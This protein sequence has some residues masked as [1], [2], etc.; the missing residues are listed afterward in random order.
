MTFVK[1][2]KRLQKRAG[3]IS[4]LT[5]GSGILSALTV[6]PAEASFDQTEINTQNYICIVDKFGEVKASNIPY[7]SVDSSGVFTLSHYTLV[8]GETLAVGDYILVGENCINL[9]QWDD[10][11]EGYLI[12]HA[13]YEAKYGDSSSWTKAAAEDMDRYFMKLAGSF[14]T[15]SDD[16]SEI[17]VTN[18][19]YI[20]F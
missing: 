9:P 5:L 15:L 13:V 16:L 19:D 7:T 4:A 10:I 12:K 2:P 18:L 3:Q 1:T 20:G 6:N 17:P 8:A 14:A 11:C